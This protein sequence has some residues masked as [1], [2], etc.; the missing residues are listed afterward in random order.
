METVNGK[1]VWRRKEY[2]FYRTYKEWKHERGDWYNV[3]AGG[4]YRTY[5]EWKHE[6]ITHE[7]GARKVFIVPIR[8]GNIGYQLAGTTSIKRF[9]RTYKEWK[10]CL[11]FLS[12]PASAGFYRT[13]KEWK[14]SY[15]HHN[16]TT[17]VRFY[18]TYKEWKLI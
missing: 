15:R 17:G 16:P 12:E 5:K 4:F 18:R 3:R 13:Y 8:N 1:S 10:Q 2:R 6:D 14:L 11:K 9:Y 7:I